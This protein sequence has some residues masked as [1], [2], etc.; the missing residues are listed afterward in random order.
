MEPKPGSTGQQGTSGSQ[1]SGSDTVSA[2]NISAG[3]SV[4]NA[5]QPPNPQSRSAQSPVLASHTSK[6]MGGSATG[7]GQ[8]S[9]GPEHMRHQDKDAGKGL[10]DQNRTGAGQSGGRSQS[11]ADLARGTAG[12][13]QQR[14]G[15]AYEQAS[16]MAG[17]AYEQASDMAGQ[18]Y[19]QASEWARGAYDQGSRQ[20]SRYGGSVQRFVSENPV[21][22]GVVGVAAGLLLGALLPRTR[23]EDRALGRWADEVRDRGMQY[24]RDMTERGREYVEE[25][26]GAGEGEE[27]F[28]SREGGRY[29]DEQRRGAAGRFQN[30]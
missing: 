26:F 9:Q 25:A 21:L 29:E 19:D 10:G 15:Q 7:S 5:G 28:P 23:H 11:A 14:A 30:H 3:T 16:E 22:V 27:R 13:V 24:A 1:R 20:V 18:A 8:S 6:P 17:Q 12:Q 2:A 4:G